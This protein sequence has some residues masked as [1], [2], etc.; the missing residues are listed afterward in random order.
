MTVP[1]TGGSHALKPGRRRLAPAPQQ[2][3]R[4]PVDMHIGARL[5]LRRRVLGLSQNDLARE[6]DVT[7]QQVCKYEAGDNRISAAK[8]YSAARVLSCPISYF[9]EGLGRPPRAARVSAENADR[10]LNQFLSRP[11]ALRLAGEFPKIRSR[12]LR[13]QLM[14]LVTC[15]AEEVSSGG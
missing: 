10:I 4:D 1:S 5:R 11:D 2:A 7:C 9:F 12:R 8:L 14:R 6:L 3:L 13:R 15:L